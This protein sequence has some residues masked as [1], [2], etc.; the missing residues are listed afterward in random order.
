MAASPESCKRLAILSPQASASQEYLHPVL[1]VRSNTELTLGDAQDRILQLDIREISEHG[2]P[3]IDHTSSLAELRWIG[4]DFVYF[5]DIPVY[6][7]ASS[8]YPSVVRLRTTTHELLESFMGVTIP[9]QYLL[10]FDSANRPFL[11]G[12]QMARLV[13]P[14][15]RQ[16]CNNGVLATSH[17][18]HFHLSFQR[19][20]TIVDEEIFP[21]RDMAKS[22]KAEDY[23]E[24]IAMGTT[25]HAI[26]KCA[27]TCLEDETA[28]HFLDK[29]YMLQDIITLYRNKLEQLWSKDIGKE[30]ERIL[31][32]GLSFLAYAAAAEP[33]INRSKTLD[34][35][36]YT[37]L[38]VHPECSCEFV[39]LSLLAQSQPRIPAVT[40]DGRELSVIDASGGAYIAI[41]HIWAD[42]LGSTAEEGLPTCQV[43]R[44]SRLARQLVPNGN[45]ET[46]A[47]G[48]MAET[49]KQAAAVLVIDEG[50]RI[51]CSVSS[52]KE[53]CLLRIATSGWMQRIWTLQEGMFARELWF[54]VSDGI[55]SCTHFNG[56]PYHIAKSLIPLLQHRP[57]DEDKLEYLSR[58][59]EPPKCTYNDLI[60]LLKH[61]KTSKAEDETIAIAGLL[62]ID[63]AEL[64]CIPSA[65]ERMRLLLIRCQ[66]L[67]RHVAMYGWGAERLKLPGFHWAPMSISDLIYGTDVLDP[68]HA[69]ADADGLKC[70]Y[71]VIHFPAIRLDQYPIAVNVTRNETDYLEH[72]PTGMNRGSLEAFP[73]L[74]A[75][76]ERTVP[77]V[78]IDIP[79]GI[80]STV[81]GLTNAVVF[82]RLNLPLSEQREEPVAL[83]YI[84]STRGIPVLKDGKWLECRFVVSGKFP[85]YPHGSNKLCT[86]GK[87]VEGALDSLRPVLLT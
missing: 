64:A 19:I 10:Q 21:G 6:S 41:S 49:F 65:E 40:F 32:A 53:E 56:P 8:P 15:A 50:I 58:S 17:V 69:T 86:I 70:L 67:P 77:G 13:V 11:S 80:V 78:R 39:R 12:E 59:L 47:I 4:T 38:H 20:I 63:A 1:G 24:F 55:L 51:Q 30:M 34:P 87:P 60:D 45:A 52:P 7:D 9:E 23:I 33:T 22:P 84:P 42:G 37:P 66:T 3:K 81:K 35:K 73:F 36:D 74:S 18:E 2:N 48:L 68:F 43:A 25:L 26:A 79:K 85:V 61:R 5:P 31:P 72:L 76:S 29:T 16:V 44:I 27:R 82:A 71:S 62:R 28:I 83:T 75:R 57:R 46:A 54:E 14:W